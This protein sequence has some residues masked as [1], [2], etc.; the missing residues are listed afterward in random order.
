MLG[1]MLEKFENSIVTICSDCV[2]GYRLS[3]MSVQ[4]LLNLLDELGKIDK[5][6]DLQSILSLFATSFINSMIQ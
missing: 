6:R 5:I 2:C 4:G 3:Y 1:N